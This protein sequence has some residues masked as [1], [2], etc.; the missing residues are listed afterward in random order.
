MYLIRIPTRESVLRRRRED[1]MEDSAANE[2]E[3]PT[4]KLNSDL[5]Y[6]WYSIFVGVLIITGCSHSTSLKDTELAQLAVQEDLQQEDITLDIVEVIHAAESYYEEGCEHY[7]QQRWQLARESF[8]TAL[9]ILLEADINTEAHYKL[10]RTYDRLFYKIHDLEGEHDYLQAISLEEDQEEELSTEQFEEFFSE[11]HPELVEQEE[12][13]VSHDFFQNDENTLGK[14]TIDPS[15]TTIMKYVKEFS[16]ERSQYRRGIE[17]RAAQYLPMMFQVFQEHG[18]P[19]ELTLVPLIESNYR[20]EAV[21]PTGAVGLWQFVRSTAKCYGLKVNKWVDERRDPEKSTIA[22]AKY[23]HDLYDMLGDWD[24]AMAGYYM[25]EY[26]VH[27]AI[28]RYRTRDISAL[29]KT[30]AFGRGA[31]L[32][33]SRIKAAIILASSP[34]KYNIQLP[35]LL[36]RSYETVS[37]KRNK[38]LKTLAKQLGVGYQELRRLNPELKHAQTPPGK[39]LYTLKVPQGLSPIMLANASTEQT[40]GTS[41]TPV[42]KHSVKI[43][44]ASPTGEY[45]TYKVKRGDNLSKIAQKYGIDA[46]V[47]KAI[48]SIRNVKSLQIGQR[49]KIPQAGQVSVA[50]KKSKVITHTVRRGDT[51]GSLAQRY[52]VSV[53]TLKSYNNIR[54]E[55]HLKIGKKLRIPA[56]NVYASTSVITH[57]IRRGETLGSLAKRYKVDVATLKSFNN[58]RNEKSLQIGQKLKVPLPKSSVLAKNDA[59]MVTYKVKRGDSLSKIASSFGVSVNQLRKWN[60]FDRGTLIFPGNRIKVWY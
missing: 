40:A 23:L 37:V 54:N 41:E 50:S 35:E 7:K 39:G 43:Q 58:V 9:E 46:D 38:G 34:E 47:L 20:V 21:S 48:N 2:G 22:A 36:P 59:E 60:N 18:V 55:R 1:E 30:K 3:T 14:V 19:T 28:G 8:D 12:L 11:I 13:Q 26:K 4:M 57:V 33:V 49:L 15:D 16:R 51:L 10:S 24:L 5:K 17:E 44:S 45:W 56:G 53:S 32:Y 52:K 31:K 42:E 25:G 6:L 29:A 27:Q